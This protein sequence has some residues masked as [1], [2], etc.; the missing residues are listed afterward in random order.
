MCI[1]ALIIIMINVLMHWYIDHYNDQCINTLSVLK[2]SHTWSCGNSRCCLV[3]S[4]AWNKKVEIVFR[5]SQLKM[6]FFLKKNTCMVSMENT[7]PPSLS[8]PK[9]LKTS[10]CSS[11]ASSLKALLKTK[12]IINYVYNVKTPKIRKPSWRFEDLAQCHPIESVT[13]SRIRWHLNI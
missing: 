11:S 1:D 10:R 2:A 4:N 6:F 9:D 8:I 5:K 13:D 7:K 3:I 12:L